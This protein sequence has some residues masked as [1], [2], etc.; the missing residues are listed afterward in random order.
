MGNLSEAAG[1][2]LNLFS[3]LA[4]ET[5]GEERE[6]ESERRGRRGREREKGKERERSE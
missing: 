5:G 6:R 1:A 2:S 4:T 3:N